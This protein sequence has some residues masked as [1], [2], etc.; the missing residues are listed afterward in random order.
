MEKR[1]D[2]IEKE[3]IKKEKL[4]SLSFLIQNLNEMTSF[5]V[6]DDFK[7]VDF[8]ILYSNGMY[9]LLEP[10]YDSIKWHLIQL[11]SSPVIRK[12]E[13]ESTCDYEI[14]IAIDTH[15]D[16]PNVKI[17]CQLDNPNSDFFHG[18]QNP[19]GIVM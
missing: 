1:N 14:E 16:N 7:S 15:F 13:I 5:R 10:I 4:N 2:W 19:R 11:L 3:K 8:G 9:V 18:K 6:N 17:E 12:I